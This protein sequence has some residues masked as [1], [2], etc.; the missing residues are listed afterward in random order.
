MLQEFFIKEFF[1]GKNG[2]DNPNI[3]GFFMDDF[4][5][6]KSNGATACSGFHTGGPSEEDYNCITD[7][8]LSQKDVDEIYD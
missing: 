1:G 6:N 5:T 2:L 8:G 3:D 4:W 7:M